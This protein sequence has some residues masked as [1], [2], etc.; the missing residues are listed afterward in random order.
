MIY[1]NTVEIRHGITFDFYLGLPHI[2]PSTV[3]PIQL[4]VNNVEVTVNTYT[5][6]DVFT[7][8]TIKGQPGGIQ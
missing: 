2:P 7:V 8:L 3:S 4:C 6:T 1:S 5:C